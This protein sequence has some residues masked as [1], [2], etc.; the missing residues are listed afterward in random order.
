MRRNAASAKLD[1]PPPA[2]KS[3][4]LYHRHV[5]SIGRRVHRGPYLFEGLTVI[6][7]AAVA[8]LTRHDRIVA[9]QAPLG[10]LA[11][12]IT[13]TG[14]CLAGVAVRS[15]VALVRR[16]RGYFRIIR[17]AGWLTDTLR[18]IVFG[19][20]AI[21]AY[22]WVKLVVP[23]YHPV[24]FD[25]ELWQLDRTLFFGLSP[26]IFF[27]QLFAGTPILRL[28]DW[29]YAYIFY[30]NITLAMA[31]FLSAPSRRL[32]VAFTNGDTILW[33][34]G[35]WLYLLLPSLGPAYRFP[36]TWFAQTASLQRTQAI[37]GMLMR[38]YTQ[39]LRAASGA[40]GLDVKI[41][42]GIGAF[43][44]LHVGFLMFVYLWMR[45]LWPRTSL[46]FAFFVFAILLGSVITGWHYLV[47]GLA[48]ILLAILAYLLSTRSCAAGSAC[49]SRA[50]SD[51]A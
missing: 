19:A 24:L 32:R 31:Y 2:A 15:V 4:L 16:Q 11:F 23:V 45:R 46:V 1:R 26:N 27:L 38:N 42:Y 17:S 29:S 10:I 6:A 9:G 28:V 7:F 51:S 37:Q 5:P 43:P 40:T 48:G 34:A 39:V 35:G 20:I 50:A 21:Y 30:V 18:L 44:S 41:V 12:A 36:E 47:D 14:Q 3:T 8:W 22:G 25:Q 49:R 33:L 13:L